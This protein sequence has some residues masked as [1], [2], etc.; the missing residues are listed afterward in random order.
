MSNV[1][2]KP[3]FDT[4]LFEGAPHYYARYR[5][6]YPVVLYDKLITEL[7]LNGEG[8]LL[9]LG[10][11]TGLIALALR[12]RFEQ[13]IGLDPD[14]EM[15]K[16]A[17]QEADQVNAHNITWLEQS[18]EQIDERLG[19]FKLITIGRA[20]HWMDRA[21]VLN[22]SYDLLEP[23]G[24][25]VLLATGGEDPWKS[26]TPWQKQALTVIKKWLGDKRRAG[27]GWWADPQPPHAELLSQS[28]F[29][30]QI[31][32]EVTYEKIWTVD[33]F[34]GYLYSTAFCLRSFLGDQI[35]AFEAE[36][37]ETLLAIDPSGQFPKTMSA[38]ALVARKQQ[39]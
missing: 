27:Q 17:K 28:L 34:I 38:S 25:F 2:T 19:T 29:P 22:R 18:A 13:I 16:E 20:F 37:R 6:K 9:D 3:N 39:I 23:S 32:Y 5:P 30:S 24:G 26:D 12:D 8:R 11:G 35:E 31:L 10:C 36:L 15:L 4:T 1:Q 21:L 14:P 33:S 7:N